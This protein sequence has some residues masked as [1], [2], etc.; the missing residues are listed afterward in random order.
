MNLEGRYGD[1]CVQREELRKRRTPSILVVDDFQVKLDL[2]L[3]IL[4]MHG[5]RAHPAAILQ[6]C[7]VQ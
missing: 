3:R 7:R 1:S 4:R 2:M 6:R 5:F